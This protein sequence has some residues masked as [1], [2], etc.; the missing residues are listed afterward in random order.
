MTLTLLLNSALP[1]PKK[2]I[3]P[4]EFGTAFMLAAVELQPHTPPPMETF[5]DPVQMPNLIAK[6]FPQILDK[7]P[8]YAR[9]APGV[10]LS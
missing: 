10:L 4:K 8:V 2:V 9:P 3:F 5:P 6:F 1:R 7:V